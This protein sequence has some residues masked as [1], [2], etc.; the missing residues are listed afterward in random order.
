M[1]SCIVYKM[2]YFYW[3]WRDKILILPVIHEMC[4]LYFGF[5]GRLGGKKSKLKYHCQASSLNPAT[6]DGEGFDW[7]AFIWWLL[8]WSLWWGSKA[9]KLNL[10]PIF[11]GFINISYPWSNCCLNDGSAEL[12]KR[13]WK[14][15]IFLVKITRRMDF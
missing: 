11:S 8:P 12:S 15:K 5:L 7:R 4:S 1:F 6:G 14:E 9:K 13:T 3:L 2:G 10:S